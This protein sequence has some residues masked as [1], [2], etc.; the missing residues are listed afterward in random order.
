MIK[1]KVTTYFLIGMTIQIGFYPIA[2]SLSCE[3]KTKD[4]LDS[5]QNSI[6]KYDIFTCK[7]TNDSRVEVISEA[8]LCYYSPSIKKFYF[9]SGSPI[10]KDTQ[11]V[12]DEVTNSIV[13]EYGIICGNE[14]H[15]YY[16]RIRISCPATGYTVPFVALN[17]ID[18]IL[19]ACNYPN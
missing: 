5:H 16:P 18:Q 8:N 4:V 17:G 15:F 11:Q 9:E 2:N 19:A 3:R 1:N 14:S 10:L 13:T 7:F 12:V 6:G